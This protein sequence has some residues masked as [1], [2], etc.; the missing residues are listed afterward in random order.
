M[1]RRPPTSTLFPYTTLFRSEGLGEL[2]E[3]HGHVVGVPGR[4]LRTFPVSRLCPGLAGVNE[5]VGSFGNVLPL[6]NRQRAAKLPHGFSQAASLG[7]LLHGDR[8]SVV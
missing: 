7:Q 8:K 1:I 6:H 2:P 5:L 4:Q 3:P